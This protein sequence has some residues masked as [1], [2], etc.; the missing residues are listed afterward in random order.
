MRILAISGS[1]RAKSSSTAVLLAL[2]S[3]A[4]AGT[5]VELYEGLA[6][7]PHFNPDV[8]EV[9]LPPEAA[10]LRARVESCSAVLICSPEYAHGV[11]GSLKNALD[12]LVGGHEMVGKPVAVLNPSAHSTFAHAQLLE[13][14]KTMSVALVPYASITLARRPASGDGRDILADP[15]LA[16][17][18]RE[19]LLYVVQF[20]ERLSA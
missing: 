18:L 8:E 20:A 1:L 12:W 19:A 3:L 7:L 11:P 5:S 15:A 6:T 16:D 10:A 17:P 14:L 9:S 4:P 13:T 2:Q